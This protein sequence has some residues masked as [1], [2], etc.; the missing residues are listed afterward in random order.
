MPNLL[1]VLWAAHCKIPEVIHSPQGI[2]IS[3]QK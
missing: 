1:V 2:I 3:L